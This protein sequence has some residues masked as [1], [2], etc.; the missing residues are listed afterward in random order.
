MQRTN[1]SIHSQSRKRNEADGCAPDAAFTTS[2][3]E[4]LHSGLHTPH[5]R[6]QPAGIRGSTAHSALPAAQ[7][8]SSP[9]DAAFTTSSEES[10]HSLAEG[11]AGAR[12]GAVSRGAEES[13]PEPD[14]A[15]PGA[16]GGA[17]TGGGAGG[18]AEEAAGP[19]ALPHAAFSASV[20]LAHP[21]KQ[22]A[23]AGAEPIMPITTGVGSAAV[24]TESS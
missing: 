5:V 11:G 9:P 24:A 19:H 17:V 8:G 4:S 3:G 13:A 7:L 21:M 16:A 20:L 22:L 12:T 10:L 2:S 14:G 6:G 23:Q 15:S 1:T 18:G